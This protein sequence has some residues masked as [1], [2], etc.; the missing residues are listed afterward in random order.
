MTTRVNHNSLYH[1]LSEHQKHCVKRGLPIKYLGASL[2]DTALHFADYE[3]PQGFAPVVVSGVTQRRWIVE[4]KKS[5]LPSRYPVGV[6]GLHSA[7]TDYSAFR[8]AASVFEMA[9]HQGLISHCLSVTDIKETRQRDLPDGDVYLIHGLTDEVV[10]SYTWPLRDFIRSKSTAL[11]LLVMTSRTP[12]EGVKMQRE[13]LR[14][15]D[16]DV[17]LCLEDTENSHSVRFT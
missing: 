15:R 9:V 2:A 16:I 7:P 11:H 5:M 1:G 17:T 14:M 3:V 4:L 13:V 12:G 8:A 10:S 6:I